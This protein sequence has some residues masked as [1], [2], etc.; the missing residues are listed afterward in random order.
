MSFLHMFSPVW[1]LCKKCHSSPYP[2]GNRRH[3]KHMEECEES[4]QHLH[5]MEWN[6]SFTNKCTMPFHHSHI[7]G[8]NWQFHHCWQTNDRYVNTST[9]KN[10]PPQLQCIPLKD[11]IWQLIA[12]YRK[13]EIHNFIHQIC[14]SR[15]TACSKLLIYWLEGWALL[16]F[17]TN[18]TAW[19]F[20]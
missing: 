6:D 16:L 3:I 9:G 12:P 4:L 15:V 11:W 7:Y 17:L 14:Y 18:L 5:Q 8:I 20:Q 1:K 19:L 10:S 2:P 13:I